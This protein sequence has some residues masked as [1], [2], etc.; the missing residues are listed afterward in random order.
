MTRWN[1]GTSIQYIGFS[2]DW[3]WIFNILSYFWEIFCHL[4]LR[5][6]K[7]TSLNIKTNSVAI[8]NIRHCETG[9]V[10]NAGIDIQSYLL[11][12]KQKNLNT[13]F[14]ITHCTLTNPYLL[15]VLTSWRG[16]SRHDHIS[17]CVVKRKKILTVFNA[18]WVAWTSKSLCNTCHR[19]CLSRHSYHVK[20]WMW[21][22]IKHT[23]T[24][25]LYVQP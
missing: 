9:R 22:Y 23:S 6:I 20:R 10:N 14:G 7:K 4:R 24:R 5:D 18:E 25:S 13:I 1:N 8:P 3:L 2:L 17:N 21:T 15:L 19:K 12:G 11:L 16:T